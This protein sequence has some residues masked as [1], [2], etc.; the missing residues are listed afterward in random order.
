MRSVMMADTETKQVI[1]ESIQ[2]AAH[3]WGGRAFTYLAWQP[4]KKRQPEYEDSAE[5]P[6]NRE[7]CAIYVQMGRELW[8]G[9][10]CGAGDMAGRVVE[11]AGQCHS[12]V[13][14]L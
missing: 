8:K 5:E 13:F 3:S 7:E 4:S 14:L 1:L 12:V 11:T 2:E 6:Y 10:C 9:R